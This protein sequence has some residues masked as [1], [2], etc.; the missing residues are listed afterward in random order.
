MKAKMEFTTP[1]DVEIQFVRSFAAERDSV[2]A[3]WTQ[4][5]HLRNWWGP[6]GFTTP[7][8]KVDFRP[9]GTWFYCM[10]DPAG[11]RYCGKMIYQEIEAPLRFSAR[12][13]F[14]DEDGVP[15]ANMPEADSK[16][17]FTEVAGETILTTSSRYRTREARD[18][19]IDMG[20]EAGLSQ[21]LDRLDAYLASLAE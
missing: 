12:D 9:G 1:S 4:A 16:F 20:V 8:C 14:T 3:M 13:I 21:T 18:Q 5:E 6:Q 15:T 19:I 11:Q 2:W 17:E 10:Q 7:V